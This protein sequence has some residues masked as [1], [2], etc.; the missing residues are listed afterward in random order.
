MGRCAAVRGG[1]TQELVLFLGLAPGRM[2]TGKGTGDTGS[3]GNGDGVGSGQV[4]STRRSPRA[5][6]DH[7][8]IGAAVGPVAPDSPRVIVRETRGPRLVRGSGDPSSR[9]RRSP[10]CPCAL[11]PENQTSAHAAR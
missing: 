10:L 11:W 7:A 8:A 5:V 9:L 3:A 4:S 1:G 2:V 6:G